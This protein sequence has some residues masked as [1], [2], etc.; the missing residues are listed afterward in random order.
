VNSLRWLDGELAAL[1]DARLLRRRVPCRPIS[2]AVVE[3]DGSRLVNFASNDYLGLAFD[4]RV[5][6][7]ARDD[8][9]TPC[10]G[11]GA[12]PLLSGCRPG[13]V[14][15]EEA[16]ACFEGA[17]A[18]ILF[19][20][21]Y[22]ANL[23]VITALVGSEDAIFSDA[24]NHASIIDGCRLS[25]ARTFVYPHADLEWLEE[26]LRGAH[27]YRRRLIVSDGLFSMDGDLAPVDGLVDL[28]QRYDAMLMI[29]EA[30]ATGVFGAAGRGAS[31][32]HAVDSRVDI[33]VGTLSKAIGAAGGFCVGSR[34]L[35]EWLVNRAR[36]YIFSTAPPETIC[37]AASAALSI[38]QRESHSRRT[39]LRRAAELRARLADQGWN[40]GASQSQIIPLI[41]GDEASA[42]RLA[43]ELREAGFWAPAIR[44]PS[45]G[46]GEAR[47]RIS[48]TAA[49]TREMVDRL[50][51]TL[52]RLAD[53]H[54]AR[55]AQA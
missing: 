4:P 22:A 32:H 28:A 27:G 50:A 38:I 24:K 34:R 43:A 2:A 15:L 54:P 11:S 39:L 45:V 14:R 10:C 8:G 48:L 6:A 23:G 13:H 12:S 41:V 17:Q 42:L 30:H 46:R 51:E 5:V 37:R 52:H 21:G 16:L 25:R 29:D 44:P 36:P 33:R 1:A 40:I 3:L 49:H 55:A 18:A 19:P 26:H 31:E 7:T 53:R 9:P 35:I 47:L 20:T